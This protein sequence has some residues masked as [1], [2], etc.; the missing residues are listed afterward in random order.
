MI[1]MSHYLILSS[2]LFSISLAGIFL[3][4]KNIIIMLMS[5]E[6]MF[7][8]INFN[9]IIFGNYLNDLTGQI[10]VFFILTVVAAESAI[11]LAIIVV[12]YRNKQGIN[13]EDIARLKG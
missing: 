11:G 6:L 8:S 9:F 5:L 13:V 10:F 7:L 1:P 2:I 4:R 3:N 12:L